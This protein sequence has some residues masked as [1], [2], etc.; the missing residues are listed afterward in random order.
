VIRNAQLDTDPSKSLVKTSGKVLVCLR[1]DVAGVLVKGC[2]EA[3]HGGLKK[4]LLLHRFDVPL[5]DHASN[6]SKSLALSRPVSGCPRKQAGRNDECEKEKVASI[7]CPHFNRFEVFQ[8][9]VPLAHLA[10][11]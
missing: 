5:A 1:R 2:K 9:S 6:L 7:H 4:L 8:A 3:G 11:G 10:S